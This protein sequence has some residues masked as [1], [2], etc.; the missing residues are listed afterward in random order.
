MPHRSGIV[1]ASFPIEALDHTTTTAVGYKYFYVPSSCNGMNIIRAQSFTFTAGVGVG[2]TV[3]QLR[4]LTKYAANDALST[5]MSIA[6]G[7]TVGTPGVI[8]PAYD[9]VSTDDCL[10][11]SCS[12]IPGTPGLGLY[13]VLEFQLP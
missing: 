13:Y 8:A 3:S 11:L 4:N 2:S 5:A 1:I 9:D 12:A 7:D 6:S 10:R